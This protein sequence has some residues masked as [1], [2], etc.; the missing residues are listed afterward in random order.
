MPSEADFRYAIRVSSEVMESNG[1]TSMARV[2]GG[3]LALMDA[4]VPLKTPVAGISV[5]LVTEYGESGEHERYECSPTSSAAKI[6]SATWISNF[7]ARRGRHGIP[8]RPQA[9]GISHIFMPKRFPAKDARTDSRDDGR[10]HCKPRAPLSK[11]APRIETA[12]I[13][14]DKFGGLI[15]PGG[16]TSK[17]SSPR[18]ALRSTSKTMAPFTSTRPGGDNMERAK[19]IIRHEKRNRS[20]QSYHGPVV[21]IKEFGAFVEVLPGK[22]G[23]I[24]ISELADFRSTWSKTS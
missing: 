8:A 21:S 10:G 1:S 13:N 14:P 12:L 24:H 4:G 23:L 6:I 17:A 9:P 11:F 7:V 19:E 15:G 5:G 2:C 20:R 3:M 22:D 18:P 16:K